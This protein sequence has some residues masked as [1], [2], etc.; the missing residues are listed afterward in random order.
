MLR[1]QLEV[2]TVGMVLMALQTT[3]GQQAGLVSNR[4]SRAAAEAAGGT[5]TK[6][7]RNAES[8]TRVLSTRIDLID[9]QDA[10]F[11]EVLEWI[12]R[13]GP[14]NVVARWRALEAEGVGPDAL[15]SLRMG[16][17]AVSDVLNEVLD[18]L[19]EG[20]SLR[21]HGV[22]NTLTVSTASDFNRKLVTR[23]YDVTDL[24]SHVPNFHGPRISLVGGQGASGS[25]ST[26]LFTDTAAPEDNEPT[27]PA[28]STGE[29]HPGVRAVRG[30]IEEL[31]EPGSWHKNGGDGTIRGFG[32]SIVVRNT[33]EVHE[34]IAGRFTIP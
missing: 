9:W 31:I 17:A 34:M 8:V 13:R 23:V 11:E 30:L 3:F 12:R 20:D 10:T 19:A 18:Q 32:K 14:I 24:V 1:K 16:D 25:G 28:T 22:G 26:Q 33:I 7:A 29:E 6:A 2:L 15:V 27:A 21:F 5:T 4:E